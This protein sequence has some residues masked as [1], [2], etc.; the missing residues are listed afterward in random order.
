MMN[1]RIQN[2]ITHYELAKKTAEI[3]SQSGFGS[4]KTQTANIAIEI[5]SDTIEC[6]KIALTHN[7]QTNKNLDGDTDGEHTK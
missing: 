5:F 7:D 4:D 3:V 2:L 1:E 6:L